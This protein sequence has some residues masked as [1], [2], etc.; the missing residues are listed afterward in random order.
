[1]TLLGQRS[2]NELGT[3]LS[4]VPFCVLDLETTG[5][6]P[7]ICEITEIGAVRYE[8][9][10]ETG[11]FQTLVNPGVG[12]PPQVTVITGIT[13]AMVIDAPTIREALPSFLEFIGEAVIVGHNVSFDISFLNAA[14]IRLGYG[15]LQ[16]Q[17]TDTLRLARRLVRQEVR[18]LKLS[19]LAAHFRS[20][21]TPNHRALDDALATAHVFWCLLERAG[22]I[23]V[24]HLDD[25]LSLPSIKGSRAIGKLE[26][27]EGI[28]RG[29]GVYRFLDA[30]GNV[31]YIGKATNLRARVRSYFAGDTRRTVDDMLRDLA[32]IDHQVTASELEASVLELREIH[33]HR[34]LYNKRSKPPK[35][36]HWVR[37]TDE[38]HPRFQLAR[39]EGKG[40]LD[41]GPFRSRR[42][43]EQVMFA[44]WDGSLIRR[45][46]SPGRGCGFA[47]LG[48]ATCPC[49]GAVS[50]DEYRAIVDQLVARMEQDPSQLF[51]RIESRMHV[52]A[53]HRRFEEA[54]AIR[55]R[56][57]ALAH[58]LRQ[59]RAWSALQLAGRFTAVD[60]DGVH[61]IINRGM[62]EA[63]WK[64]TST[65]PLPLTPAD[66]RLQPETMA[67]LDEAML[68][69]S[70]LNREGVELLDLTGT[71]AVPVSGIPEPAPTQ[72]TVV[73]GSTA[74]SG[75]KRTTPSSV[76][77]PMTRTSDRKPPTRIGSKPVTATT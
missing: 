29:P 32:A 53:R 28:P 1:M 56:R 8:S 30:T 75:R 10:I 14:S 74:R 68:V 3:A 64:G 42:A 36:L 2:F 33:E 27:T 23:G 26:L 31:I 9:G 77:A 25:L 15:R 49:S 39:S 18:S 76:I 20:E 46:T 35:S 55:D 45:C 54:A 17:S 6:G 59:R 34:P 13:Q 51:D 62:L 52:L 7:D 41:L 24:T 73:P 57:T 21:T 19:S 5:V 11:R 65:A 43:A 66:K 22:A 67:V 50:D 69:W 16:N 72:A 61:V 38:Q 58:A 70:W 71:L 40:S 48:V 4:E 60:A 44:L 37:L 47:E 12:I 63:C